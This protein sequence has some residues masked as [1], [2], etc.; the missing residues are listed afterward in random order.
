MSYSGRIRMIL[1]CK[2]CGGNM[3]VSVDQTIGH[4]GRQAL[5][6][7]GGTER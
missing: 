7:D 2:L 5:Y 1:K 3:D 4:K 6:V